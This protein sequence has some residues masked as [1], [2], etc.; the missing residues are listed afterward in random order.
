MG[1]FMQ[2]LASFKRHH[3]FQWRSRR[4][5]RKVDDILQCLSYVEDV[6][7]ISLRKSPMGGWNC[8]LIDLTEMTEESITESSDDS[9]GL[10]DG[11]SHTEQSFETSES[12]LDVH[13]L[14]GVLQLSIDEVDQTKENSDL[15][16]LHYFDGALQFSVPMDRQR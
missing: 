15:D 7:K 8:T 14:D 10:S 1:V 6:D 5:R 9:Y 3:T 16:L 11:S 2:A 4:E 12:S 13:Y